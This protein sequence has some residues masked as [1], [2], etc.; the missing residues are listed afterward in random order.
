MGKKNEE[1]KEMAVKEDLNPS[2]DINGSW[3]AADDLEGT[4]LVV[5]RVYHQQALSKFVQD[6]KAQAG[7]WCDNL[8]GEVLA[9]KDEVLPV[10]IFHTERQWAISIS[11]LSNNNFEF[12]RNEA[13]T[14]ENVNLPW[15]QETHEGTIKRQFR[16]NYFCLLADKFDELPYVI[17]FSSTKVKEAKR[18][19]TVLAKLKA[20]GHSSARF[21]F[22]L[23]SV[24]ESKVKDGKTLS[25][26]NVEVSQGK[27]TSEEQFKAAFNWFLKAKAQK[28]VVAEDTEE[29]EVENSSSPKGAQTSMGEGYT[30]D[31]DDPGY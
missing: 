5:S 25:W 24:K 10:I 6:A 22:Y 28:I 4:D 12:V 29:H 27:S 19:N 7:D 3:G 15:E 1:I 13:V 2:T 14:P 20:K 17:T 8:T 30:A 18:L 26:F 9:K 16:Y 31:P 21:I 11:K 23:M